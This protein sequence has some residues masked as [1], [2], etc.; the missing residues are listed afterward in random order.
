MADFIKKF[1]LKLIEIYKF[2][3]KFTPPCCRFTPTCSQY[4][5]EAIQKFGTHKGLILGIKRI[6][7]CHPFSEGGYD[8]VPDEY[9]ETIG[10]K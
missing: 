10:K 6:L 2:F 7:R 9:P 3:S 1:F 4:T 5:Y 8:P